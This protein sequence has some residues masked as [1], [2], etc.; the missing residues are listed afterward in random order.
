MFNHI[1][2]VQLTACRR[3]SSMIDWGTPGRGPW[4]GLGGR[5]WHL[6][7]GLKSSKEPAKQRAGDKIP[8]GNQQLKRRRG[9]WRS[10]EGMNEKT[11]GRLGQWEA[12][13]PKKCRLPCQK[14]CDST[15]VT[16]SGH[17]PSSLMD[18]VHGRLHTPCKSPDTDSSESCNSLLPVHFS[19]TGVCS[20][21]HPS[22]TKACNGPDTWQS[23]GL[24]KRER[25][26]L[27]WALTPRVPSAV[28]TDE[29]P[30]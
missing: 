1:S 14:L 29:P 6:N 24:G 16:P 7:W 30:W 22:L 4:N 28:S 19:C 10:W 9:G 15:Q 27:L 3:V 20:F 8:G 17:Y 11:A 13:R 5:R 18:Q 23:T 2:W 25:Q 26:P 12:Q 21:A